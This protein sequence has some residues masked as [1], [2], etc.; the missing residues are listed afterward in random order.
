[1][2]LARPF[3]LLGLSLAAATCGGTPST[4]PDDTVENVAAVDLDG[5]LVMVA[6]DAN[7]TAIH[8]VDPSTGKASKEQVQLL[9]TVHADDV[10]AI[11]P[12]GQRIA[13]IGLA[14]DTSLRVVSVAEVVVEGGLPAFRVVRTFEGLI[15]DRLRWSPDGDRL[16]TR[17]LWLDP[18][19]G[20]VTD[21]LPAP[22][23]GTDE[24]T[25]EPIAALPGGH[26]YA[27]PEAASLFDDGVRVADAPAGG[28][29][30]SADGQWWG[31]TLHVPSLTSRPIP[32]EPPFDP[33]VGGDGAQPVA[34]GEG[35]WIRLAAGVNGTYVHE[36]TA[37]WK[38]VYKVYTS[39]DLPVD[40]A[41][42]EVAT[43]FATGDAGPKKAWP[44]SGVLDPW[45]KDG[46]GR[47]WAPVGASDDGE[48]VTYAVLSWKIVQA[49]G[50]ASQQSANAA[51][52]EVDAQGKA[53]GF[54]TSEV[55]TPFVPFGAE[56]EGTDLER[57]FQADLIGPSGRLELP[58]GDWLVPAGAE[59]DAATSDTWIGYL[60]GE[61]AAVKGAGIASRDGGTFLGVRLDG[62]TW[63]ICAR[64]LTGSTLGGTKCFPEPLPG[65]PIGVMGQGTKSAH[66]SDAP[67]VLHLSRRAAWPGSRVTVHGAHFGAGGTVKVGGVAV[68]S[69]D[70]VAW[71]DHRIT[72]TMTA[73]LPAK[74]AVEVTTAAGT[75]GATRRFWLHRTKLA[76]SPFAK[77]STAPSTLAQGLNPVALGDLGSI[78][79]VR[80]DDLILDPAARLAD[81]RTVVW[82]S[83]ATPPAAREVQLQSGPYQRLLR[84]EVQSAIADPTRW[85][86]V[87]PQAFDLV[88]QRPGFVTVAGE[89]LERATAR[90][91]ALADRFTFPQAA[92]LPEQWREV[93]GGALTVNALAGPI[94][95]RTL[96]LLT[97]WVGA[98]GVWGAPRYAASPSVNLPQY[99]QGAAADGDLVIAVGGDPLGAPGA[100]FLFSHDGGKTLGPVQLA[101]AKL[102]ASAAFQHP[103]LVKAQ[104]GAFFL[105]FDASYYAPQISGVHA[106]AEDGTITA[107]VAPVPPDALI[108]GGTVHNAPV[109][110]AGEGGR[111]AVHFGASK[112]LSVID[113]DQAAPHTWKVAPS[114]ADQGRV[115]SVFDDPATRDLFAVLADGT[116][117]R[118]TAAGHWADWSAVDLG[119]ELALPTKVT[120]VAVGK[121]PDGRLIVLAALRT[122][123]GAGPCPIA[124]H[125]FLVGPKP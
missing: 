43:V 91:P 46:E 19:T 55:S 111:V 115:V 17:H 120:P 102:P 32:A 113:F 75:G 110:L 64:P 67:L 103:V 16:F 83:G 79:P 74:G 39:T 62:S 119:I 112:T 47:R 60:G 99:F 24:G 11:S 84:F 2:K 52:I 71:S 9:N 107:D 69:A 104:A 87:Q 81:G 26:L 20:A 56:V 23:A 3:L 72:F 40:P 116:V 15:A 54:K 109:Q 49:G 93:P 78:A 27:C 114:A 86:L 18:E 125:G 59:S 124:A 48:H 41:T 68:K 10:V 37:G 65:G 105:V 6:R 89:L 22:I 53:R 70:V 85:Q 63:R 33:V 97:G 35:R 5:F 36:E 66:A 80:A 118:A 76:D 82:S 73:A 58:G 13:W 94:Y 25:I 29:L 57:H 96:G 61:P 123:D 77:L 21:C 28:D 106:V 51:L 7:T 121:L 117:S 44:L 4:P 98:D 100:A 12:D 38:T 1:M 90:H 88:A 92:S 8:L 95:P 45:M 34:A 101:A 30:R 42:A 31:A 122:S 50:H 14:P 108:D